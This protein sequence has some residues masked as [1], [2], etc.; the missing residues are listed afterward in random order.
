MNMKFHHLYLHV[1][2]LLGIDFLMLK[3]FMFTKFVALYYLVIEKEI[4]FGL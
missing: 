4:K 1:D 3:K 2:T